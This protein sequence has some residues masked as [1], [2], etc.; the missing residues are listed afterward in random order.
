M[1]PAK[2]IRCG[3]LRAFHLIAGR[4]PTLLLA[5]LA[6]PAILYGCGGSSGSEGT[7]LVATAS[8]SPVPSVTHQVPSITPE[9][10]STP[11]NE[12]LVAEAQVAEPFA[13]AWSPAGDLIAVTTAG[14]LVLL[15]SSDLSAQR[16]ISTDRP[17]E[18]LAFRPGGDLLATTEAG[19]RFQLWTMPSGDLELEQEY[20]INPTYGIAFDDG[21]DL[22]L[23][24]WGGSR[25]PCHQNLE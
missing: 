2:G 24:T 25:R 9:P 18:F 14:G 10:S 22:F 19:T 6:F 12:G 13:L 8:P 21:G 15:Q 11:A 1:A 20:T 7:P 16:L 23:S 3:V 4:S 5:F 17:L